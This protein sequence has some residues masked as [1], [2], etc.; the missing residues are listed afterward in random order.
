MRK[1]LNMVKANYRK[2][3]K[4][5]L[6]FFIILIFSSLLLNIGL[7]MTKYGDLYEDK[8]KEFKTP[9]ML[10]IMSGD[11]DS[12]KK[13]APDD[14]Y[15]KDICF[16]DVIEVYADL[17]CNNSEENERQL[18]F[19]DL[20]EEFELNDMHMLEESKEQY[21]HPIYISDYLVN[22]LHAEIG[23]EITIKN[24]NL[25]E[26]TYNIAG[27]YENIFMNSYFIDEYGV[28]ISHEDFLD[29]SSEA[30]KVFE[31][32][33]PLYNGLCVYQNLKDGVTL[34][35]AESKYIEQVAPYTLAFGGSCWGVSISEARKIQL[36]IPNIVS[37][38]CCAV[39]LMVLLISIVIT[40]FVISDNI[41]REI[42]NIGALK[43]IGYTSMDLKAAI[44][45]E[46]VF[47]TIGA[48][49]LGI[50]LSYTVFPKINNVIH[51]MQGVRLEFGFM[52]VIAII[53][54]SFFIVTALLITLCATKRLGK[55]SPIVALR[56]GL[57]SHSFKKNHMPLKKH[58]GNITLLLAL[59]TMLQQK[60]HN[61]ILISVSMAISIILTFA[62]IIFYNSAIDITSFNRALQG[63]VMDTYIGF[64][65][66]IMKDV[67]KRIAL[68]EEIAS[69]EEVDIVNRS[70]YT[71][72]SANNTKIYMIPCDHVDKMDCNLTEG[73]MPQEDNEVV[74][75]SVLAK[76]LNVG[77]GNE[78][79]LTL[80]DIKNKFIISGIQ[81]CFYG[82]GVRVYMSKE[83]YEKFGVDFNYN[84]FE[85]NLKDPTVEKVDNFIE[86]LK[87][88]YGKD[89]IDS[90][91][92]YEEDRSDSNTPVM[93]VKYVSVLLVIISS[94]IVLLAI[95]LM[96]KTEIIDKQREYGIK[97]S[98]GFT[99]N[100]LRVQ[101]AIS[102]IPVVVIGSIIGT[103]IGYV[104]GNDIIALMCSSFAI[105]N[106][107][108]ITVP[109]MIPI[110]S[111]F[112]VLYTFIVAFWMSKKVK[113]ITAYQ[114]ITE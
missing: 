23:D 112:V 91:N 32:E 10:H 58:S 45:L 70:S 63:H 101:L 92:V 36:M 41:K 34:S 69:M 107:G 59:K 21:E 74:I 4:Q 96:V 61:V 71:Y 6:P 14:K 44:I 62:G 49:V 86:K 99:S 88:K 68:E 97:K 64:D 103:F 79:E 13:I 66:D 8:L 52:P 77:V 113:T 48:S 12:I 110:I 3:V 28:R 53:V 94:M 27:I 39:A 109:A 89:I 1:V 5:L 67:E 85:I 54:I 95:S 78:I 76:E 50:I 81:E 90:S 65:M 29:L 105:T 93:A 84:Y 7:M 42:K 100:Q 11:T 73:S 106:L 56:F 26:R 98:I 75:G 40:M 24:S 80:G 60:R 82:M 9:D 111:G 2:D 19:Y 104:F 102:M 30:R 25:K 114:L 18:C 51:P 33:G 38:I 46:Y 57:N 35:D 15:I 83:S 43:A 47:V 108:F 20:S 87:N 31:N 72:A 22:V 37:A 16:Y 17:A 55:L